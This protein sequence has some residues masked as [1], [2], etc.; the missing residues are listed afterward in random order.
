MALLCPVNVMAPDQQC[1]VSEYCRDVAAFIDSS[2]RNPHDNITVGHRNNSYANY[3]NSN[4]SKYSNHDDP[5]FA[6]E[7]VDRPLLGSPRIT[8][9]LT[10]QHKRVLSQAQDLLQE[11]MQLLTWRKGNLNRGETSDLLRDTCQSICDLATSLEQSWQQAN[12]GKPI[13][14]W[15]LTQIPE[16]ELAQIG[17]DFFANR[18]Q[19]RNTGGSM[20]ESISMLLSGDQQANYAKPPTAVAVATALSRTLERLREASCRQ[21]EVDFAL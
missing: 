3:S 6:E 9:M 21:W 14:A 15:P 2:G 19:I 4:S 12:P 5:S 16:D 7:D 10:E 13:P 20:W 8:D 17:W 11:K 18:V 1:R